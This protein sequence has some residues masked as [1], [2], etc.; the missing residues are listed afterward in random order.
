MQTAHGASSRPE[1]DYFPL[2][3]GAEVAR[4]SHWRSF[5]AGALERALSLRQQNKQPQECRSHG[6]VGPLFQ[7]QNRLEWEIEQLGSNFVVN[8]EFMPVNDFA[9]PYP[10]GQDL[11]GGIIR[12]VKCGRDPGHFN[13]FSIFDE[14]VAVLDMEIEPRHMMLPLAS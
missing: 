6:I 1:K 11:P 5:V 12:L 9:A 10:F 7:L 8:F 14:F 2:G 4:S 3:I 13:T